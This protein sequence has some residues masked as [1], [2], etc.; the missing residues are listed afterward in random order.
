MELHYWVLYALILFAAGIASG[1]ASG[2]FGVGG[3]IVRIPIFLVL[4]PVFGVDPSV[5]MHLAA[6][7][8]LALAVPSAVTASRAQ[9]KAGN[10]DIGFL[11]SWVPPLVVGV[12]AGLI[13]V[14][15]VSGRSLEGVFAFVVLLIA[16]QMLLTAD[17]F[18]LMKDF[19][20]RFIK[21][22]TAFVIGTLSTLIG[23][24]GGTF[25]TP[26]L[27]AFGYSIHRSIAVA[28]A[29][30]FFI[31]TIGALG[32]VINGSGVPGRPAFSLGYL[33][34]TAL[35]V[36]TPAVM[37]TAPLGVRLAIRLSQHKLKRVFALFLFIVAFDMLYH[38]FL[39]RG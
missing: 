34:L 31:S 29:S 27:M 17:K 25:T 39:A 19:P 10:L 28:T 16:V 37:A 9:Y 26:S 36:M 15:H 18:K 6:G 7:T 30:G 14:R 22:A 21:S 1:F 12:F 24:T 33:D 20:G 13:I 11:R 32:W 5:V 2:L 4:F 23:I 8:S 3:G 38:V 35:L